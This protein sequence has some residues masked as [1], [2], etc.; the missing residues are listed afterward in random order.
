MKLNDTDI[1][2]RGVFRRGLRYRAVIRV[3]GAKVCLG[4]FDTP[5]EAAL[6]YNAKLADIDRDP[7]SPGP[8]Q[9][10]NNVSGSARSS[11]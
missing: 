6:A 7:S 1:P 9:K 10:P 4:T 11:L 8:R 5:E 2:Y 3:R